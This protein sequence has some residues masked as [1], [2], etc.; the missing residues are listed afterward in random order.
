[1]FANL[2]KPAASSGGGSLFGSTLN[3]NPTSSGAQGS[4]LFGTAPS[5]NT[6]TP[7]SGGLFG[8]LGQTSQTQAKPNLFGNLG[9][10]GP[11][12]NT[13]GGGGGG[14]LFGNSTTTATS[15]PQQQQQ[16]P[17]QQQQQ[18]Q[19]AHLTGGL[20]G[21]NNAQQ[22]AGNTN[23]LFSSTAQGQQSNPFGATTTNPVQQGATQTAGAQQD[24]NQVPK[25]SQPA[26]FDQLLERGK[27]RQTVEK[28]AGQF[29]ELPSLQLG[30]GDIAR[31]VRNLGQGGPNAAQRPRTADSRAY[32]LESARETLTPS[33]KLSTDITFLLP[34]A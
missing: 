23:R 27:K 12:P 4:S 2:G 20:F 1:M 29:G 11:S 10:N 13:S 25:S 33:D 15:Q 26:F 3:N 5:Q 9:A 17:E 24:Q 7:S 30:L 14:G 18:Q 21:S 6:T 31:K 22:P 16:T 8:N 28:D 32:V 19:Q 34:R